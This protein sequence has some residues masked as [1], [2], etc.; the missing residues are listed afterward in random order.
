VCSVYFHDQFNKNN[1]V[2]PSFRLLCNNNE[3]TAC[4]A[5]SCSFY[6]EVYVV[7]LF[8]LMQ[9][10]TIG[11]VENSITFCGHIISVCNSEELLKWDS[12]CHSYAQMK[13][14]P[15]LF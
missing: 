12:I 3:I 5:D 2:Q 4:T 11:E 9:Q 1:S 14:D 10:Q 13:M 8:K 7:P 6:E 15:V